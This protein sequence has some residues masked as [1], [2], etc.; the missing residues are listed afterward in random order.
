MRGLDIIATVLIIIGALNWGVIG[1]F[2]FDLVDFLVEGALADRL[3]YIIFGVAGLF[4]VIY[5]F[6]GEWSMKFTDN[7]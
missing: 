5:W 1:V 4:K 7:E 3:V 6:A 2:Y